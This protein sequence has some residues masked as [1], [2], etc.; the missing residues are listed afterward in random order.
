M[1]FFENLWY[2]VFNVLTFGSLFTI[3]V[4]IKKAITESK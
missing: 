2:Y 3:K 1:P 4:I